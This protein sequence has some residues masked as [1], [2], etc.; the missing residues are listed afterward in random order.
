M[1]R[2]IRLSFVARIAIIVIFSLIAIQTLVVM[3]YF[4]Q[5]NSNTGSGFKPPL[6][7]Q[8]AAMVG[9]I[10]K[11]PSE[12][13]TDILRAVNSAQIQVRIENAVA[14]PPADSWRSSP[15]VESLL[16]SYLSALENRQVTVLVQRHEPG[17]LSR[18]AP[19]NRHRLQRS[20]SLS[21]RA[22][23]S[24]LKLGDRFL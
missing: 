9:L 6:P 17:I 23:I 1:M 24:S 21:I 14:A 22:K 20:L 15:V 18:I 7:D 13:R 2:F 5:R 16:R 11:S 19:F 10:E 3:G 8:V 4:I 12:M